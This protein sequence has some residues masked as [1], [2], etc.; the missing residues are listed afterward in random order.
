MDRVQADERAA[1]VAQVPL[2]ALPGWSA[3]G[4]AFVEQTPDGA[5]TLVVTVD[6]DT[7]DGGFR[8]VWLIDRD[9]TRLVSLGVLDGTEGRFVIPAGLDLAEFPVVDVSE[10]PFDGNPGHSGDSIIRGVLPA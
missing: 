8:E 7:G 6:G 4:D 5:R 2:E 9:V 10:E 3:S 1:V